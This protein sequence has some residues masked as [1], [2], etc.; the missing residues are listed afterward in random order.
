MKCYCKSGKSFNKC[1]KPFLDK[2][3]NPSSPLE[4]MRSRY[5]AYVLKDIDYLIET[6]YPENRKFYPKDELKK[7][8]ESSNF[9]NLE[10][11]KSD[12]KDDFGIVEFKAYYEHNGD[13]YIHHEYSTFIKE[14]G[15]WYFE[16]GSVF[17]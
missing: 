7:W 3:K 16:E 14:N 15:I 10:I 9:F 2:K 5:T 11:I 17:E 4:L 13:I 8:A 1:C 6:T 12:K